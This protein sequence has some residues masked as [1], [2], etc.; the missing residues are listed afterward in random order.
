MSRLPILSIL[1][2]TLLR[3]IGTP[4]LVG[5]L[6]FACMDRGDR[7]TGPASVDPSFSAVQAQDA[8]GQ[9]IA[10]QN[11]HTARLLAIRGVVG[12]ATGI[13]SNGR[14]A[15]VVFTRAPGLAGIPGTLESVGVETRVVGEITALQQIESRQAAGASTNLRRQIRP[16]PNGVSVSNN[17]QCAAGTLGTAV[18][19]NGAKYALSNNHVFARENAAAI[20]E[21]IVQPGRFDNKPKCADQLATDQIGTLADFQPINFSGGD[22]TIDAAIAVATTDLTCSTPAGFYGSPSATTVGATLGLAIQKVG[23]TSGLTTGAVTAINATV[24]VGYS[25]GTARFVN[26]IVTTSRFSKAGD[27]GSLIVTNDGTNR[28]VGLLFAGTSDG[29]TVGNLIDPVLQR[30]TAAICHI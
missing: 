1:S 17:N 5:M 23:R 4:V 29:T 15:V 22:N 11:R 24:N 18:L 20:G 19:L 9:V 13:G 2:L 10:I 25:T 26:Q 8:I 30:F 21:P 28:P 3:R 7:T 16:V 6:V 12:T 27:S 14:P